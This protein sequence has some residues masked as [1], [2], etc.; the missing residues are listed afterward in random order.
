MRNS[1]AKLVVSL[2]SFITLCACN[3]DEITTPIVELETAE[4]NINYTPS[5]YRT[6]YDCDIGCL[7][8]DDM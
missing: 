6:H 1:Y 2:M 5:L 3:Q 4:S 7:S 8:K